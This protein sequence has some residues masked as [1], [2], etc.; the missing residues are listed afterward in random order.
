MGK[1]ERGNLLGE[2]KRWGDQE[3]GTQELRR[4]LRNPSLARPENFP[5]NRRDMICVTLICSGVFPQNRRD[6][7]C[8]RNVGGVRDMS[9]ASE[10][11]FAA[12]VPSAP[13]QNFDRGGPRGPRFRI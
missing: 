7:I 6:M 1:T 3:L 10:A 11:R 13:T 4:Q 5:Q 2:K 9:C 8:V 12:L